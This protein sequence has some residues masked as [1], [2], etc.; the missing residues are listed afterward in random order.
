MATTGIIT[1]NLTYRELLQRM[2]PDGRLAPIGEILTRSNPF[3][4]DAV[5]REGNLPTGHRFT[6]RTGLP[7]VT[8][9]RFNKGVTP[10]KSATGQVTETTT[11]I[12]GL[13]QVDAREADMNGNAAAFRF[14]EDAAFLQSFSNEGEAALV[15][16][17]Q[18][19]KAENMS[20]IIP[21]Y[22]STTGHGGKQIILHDP[23]A[24]GADQTSILLVG[25][26][27]QSVYG[28]VPKGMPGGLMQQDYGKELVDDGEGGVFPAYRTWWEQHMGLCVQDYRNIVRIANIDLGN[29]ADTGNT[30]IRSMVKAYHLIPN[31]SAVR[32]A[33]YANRTIHTFLHL[34]ALDSVKNSTLTIERIG[35]EPIMMFLGYP[36]HLTDG[37]TSTESVVA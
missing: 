34:Q 36:V 32:L 1:G 11:Q 23:A 31:P 8:R 10:S 13:S 12:V 16:D 37:I 30:L 26:G 7:S 21:R 33:W 17:S 27:D 25:W 19:T 14:S 28:I 29:L 9:R 18:S 35:G 4:R 6:S 15:Y 24:S 20:G 2:D 22:S 3:Y 5:F